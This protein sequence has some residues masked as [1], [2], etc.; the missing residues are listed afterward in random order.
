MKLAATESPW[1]PSTLSVE[2]HPRRFTDPENSEQVLKA[3][4]AAG[5]ADRQVLGARAVPSHVNPTI[6]RSETRGRSR[7][8]TPNVA[9]IYSASLMTLFRQVELAGGC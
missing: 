7:G 3:R 5:A 2:C 1:I 6:R 8:R 9:W 4:L